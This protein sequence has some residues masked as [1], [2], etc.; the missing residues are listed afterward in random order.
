VSIRKLLFFSDVELRR[1]HI[2]SSMY[3]VEYDQ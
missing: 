1:L 3:P 2:L